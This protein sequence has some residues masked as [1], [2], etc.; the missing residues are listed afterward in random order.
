MGRKVR[1]SKITLDQVDLI[2]AYIV[3]HWGERVKNDFKKELND[4]VLVL[5]KNPEIG[6]ATEAGRYSFPLRMYR[7]HYT[8]GEDFLKVAFIQVLRSNKEMIDIE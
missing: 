5:A 1:F 2:F 8:F 7:I 6:M 3:D 4:T